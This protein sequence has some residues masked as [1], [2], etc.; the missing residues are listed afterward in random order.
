MTDNIVTTEDQLIEQ[1]RE[2]LEWS[3]TPVQRGSGFSIEVSIEFDRG[4][5]RELL[6]FAVPAGRDWSFREETENGLTFY[7]VQIEAE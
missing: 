5:L 1:I 3:A 7:N 6:L 4:H 2:G